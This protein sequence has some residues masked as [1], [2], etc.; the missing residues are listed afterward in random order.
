MRGEGLQTLESNVKAMKRCSPFGV[1]LER[2]L[3]IM[4]VVLDHASFVILTKL[5]DR[6]LV[7]EGQIGTKAKS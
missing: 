4:D 7:Y 2:T 5:N 6:S 3:F 1:Q